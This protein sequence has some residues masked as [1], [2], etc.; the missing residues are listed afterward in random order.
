MRKISDI[1][2]DEQ[3]SW[4]KVP[5]DPN[6]GTQGN[7]MPLLDALCRHTGFPPTHLPMEIPSVLDYVN[8]QGQAFNHPRLSGPQLNQYTA[9]NKLALRVCEACDFYYAQLGWPKE[10][11]AQLLRNAGL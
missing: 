7:Y 6:K 3:F 5:P 11:V 9:H 1:L 8:V 2:A 4:P 10:Q